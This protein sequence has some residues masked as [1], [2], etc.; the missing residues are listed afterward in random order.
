MGFK[1]KGSSV[2]K[3]FVPPPEIDKAIQSVAMS[4]ISIGL[5]LVSFI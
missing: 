3:K 4:A 5:L 1:P 2:A